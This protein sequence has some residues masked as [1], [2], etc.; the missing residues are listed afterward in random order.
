MDDYIEIFI[1][2]QDLIT[3]SPNIPFQNKLDELIQRIEKENACSIPALGLEENLQGSVTLGVNAWMHQSVFDG[4]RTELEDT[5]GNVQVK[6]ANVLFEVRSRD[7]G[8]TRDLVG[9]LRKRNIVVEGYW[10]IDL[11]KARFIDCLSDRTYKDIKQMANEK[12]RFWYL[13]C[14][15]EKSSYFEDLFETELVPYKNGD[16]FSP[17]VNFGMIKGFVIPDDLKRYISE[18]NLY[19]AHGI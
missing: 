9:K 2:S 5:Y 15:A 16:V 6:I 12:E 17:H 13:S 18:I 10:L 4:M 3:S 7:Y 14:R 19:N 1:D 8:L 11:N